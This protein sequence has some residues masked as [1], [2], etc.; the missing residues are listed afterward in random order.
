MIA[1]IA[2]TGTLP[3]EA[4]KNLMTQGADFFVVSLFPE[5]NLSDLEKITSGAIPVFPQNVFKPGQI[6]DF[7]KKQ[8]TKKVFFIGKVDKQHLLSHIKLDWFALKIL[9]SVLYK[10]DASIMESLL[11]ELARHGIE[12]I[13]Q[14][15]ILKSLLVPPGVLTGTLTPELEVNITM[16]I[17]TAMQLSLSDI[18]Q[19]I[20]IKDKMILAVEAIEGTDSCIKRGID[21]G[22]TGIIVCKAAQLG[23]NKKFDLPTLGPASLEQLE[24]NQVSAIAWLSTHTLIA[25]QEAFIKKAQ[26]LN[27]TLVSV[28]PPSH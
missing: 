26:E 6:L 12:V 9:A 19:T 20:V 25:Q 5:N 28:A 3:I 22:K 1:V 18:G 13:K 14:D 17:T 4:C 8:N 7:L 23:Q 16:G 11:A 24:K 15:T 27:I 2:G 21:L 10:S